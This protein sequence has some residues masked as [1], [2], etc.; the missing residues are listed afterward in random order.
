MNG[1]Q[2][3]GGGGYAPPD[4]TDPYGGQEW[5]QGTDQGPS[6]WDVIS[7]EGT[8]SEMINWLGFSG[9]Q[10]DLSQAAGYLRPYDPSDEIGLGKAYQ[11]GIA[12]LS[13]QA[14][15]A[16]MSFSTDAYKQNITSGLVGDTTYSKAKARRRVQSQLDRSIISR[17][18]K[19]ETDIAGVR[20]DYVSELYKSLSA[21]E[22]LDFEGFGQG[23]VLDGGDG[24]GGG[25]ASIAYQPT[26]GDT[27][28][29]TQEEEI[30]DVY[31]TG[32]DDFYE[33][34]DYDYQD[35]HADGPSI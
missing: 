5:W 17:A 23:T 22:A 21:M 19:L 6:A 14:S 32:Q 18:D 34:D 9:T 13:E 25:S 33:Q 28:D 20:E 1:D 8:G 31:D 3:G 11:G 26:P 35:Q 4:P 30:H 2:P 27:D 10:D 15:D 12:S 16:W 24:D 29:F 7:Y